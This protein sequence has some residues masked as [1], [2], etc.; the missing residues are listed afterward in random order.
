MWLIRNCIAYVKQYGIIVKQSFGPSHQGHKEC[1]LC[2]SSNM[3][4]STRSWT[5]WAD[6]KHL[7]MII[8]WICV[9]IRKQ[10]TN[11]IFTCWPWRELW[12]CRIQ[13]AKLAKAKTL[14]TRCDR[15]AQ[16]KTTLTR[17]L[18]L[19]G[20]PGR[21][22]QPLTIVMTLLLSWP[23]LP[24]ARMNW[25]TK[26]TKVTKLERSNTEIH[27]VFLHASSMSSIINGKKH[28]LDT[29]TCLATNLDC[30]CMIPHWVSG[31]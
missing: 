27:T 3:L 30:C 29:P 21:V 7:W 18:W 10:L 22:I 5:R 8:S 2:E 6:S 17:N 4:L 28:E 11:P 25:I 14:W 1:N 12:W 16:Q 24:T 31:C 15:A 13:W 26:I 19:V 9:K 23:W 20:S